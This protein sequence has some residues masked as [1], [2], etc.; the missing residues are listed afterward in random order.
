MGAQTPIVLVSF[1][2][3]VTEVKVIFAKL[4]LNQDSQ[5]DQDE[6]VRRRRCVFLS[7]F[8]LQIN[9]LFDLFRFMKLEAF[10]KHCDELAAVIKQNQ[11]GIKASMTSGSSS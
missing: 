10:N 9:V 11:A 2:L 4:D 5:I 7:R 1:L 6:W 3:F 8:A